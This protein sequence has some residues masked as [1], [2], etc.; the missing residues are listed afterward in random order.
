MTKLFNRHSSAKLT[1]CLS[2]LVVLGAQ[3]TLL[4][5]DTI[6]TDEW[7]IEA[8]KVLRFEDPKSIIAEGN[9]VLTKLR[10]LPPKQ[11]IEEI[12]VSDWADLLEEDSSTVVDK[13]VIT[14]EVVLDET[15]RYITEITI[16]ADWIA[17]DIE[18]NSIKAKGNV[19]INNDTDELL[20]KEGTLNLN[21][22]TGTFKEAMIL[23]ESL[24]LHLE[25]ETITKT[26]TNTYNIKDGWV[27]TCKVAEEKTPPWSFAAKDTDVTQGEYAIM[28]HATFRIKDVPV[29]Y[30]PWLMVP[31]G[32]QRQTGLLF[33]EL[34]NSDRNG[35]GIN[36]PLF[37]NL[38][39]SSDIT[40][41]PEYY[42]NRGF[43]PG[44][45]YRYTLDPQDKGAFMA[46]YLDDDLSDPSETE[47]WQETGYTHTNQER[48]W[49]RGKLDHD[50]ENDIVTRM[51]LDIVSDRDYL[52]EFNS[53]ETGFQD[54]NE[55]FL[56]VFGRG[57]QNKTNDQRE[58]SFKLLKTWDGMALE[59][60]F[61][62]INDVRQDEIIQTQPDL[63]VTDDQITDDQ[64]TD[65]Q[66]TD[67]T[68]PTFETRPTPLWKLPSI[69]FTGSKAIGDTTFTLDWDTDYVYYYR[70]NGIGGHRF[71][72]YPRL[73]VP[74]PLGPYLES[75]AE[76][77]IRDTFYSVQSN[78]DATWDQGDNPNRFLGDFHTE[79]GTT[80]LRDFALDMGD[81]T[82]LTHNFRPY[83]QYDY[84]SDT[85]QDDLPEFDSV[86]R[87][88][89]QNQITY[90]IDNFFDLFGSNSEGD[91]TDR[92]YGFL[93][94]KQ[95]YDLR[96]E[97][98]DNPFSAVKVKLRWDPMDN[99]NLQYKTEIDV[100][101]AG[102]TTHTVEVAYENS[103]GD[104]FNLDYRYDNE[105]DTQQINANARA[106]LFDTI[107]AA[108][109]IEHSISE[110]RVIEQDI[111]LLYKPACW[112][113]ELK[114]RY[115]PG[116]HTISLLFNL[117]NIG[118]PL[119]LTL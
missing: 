58:N 118:N 59:G 82:G 112:S 36:L 85:N 2:S 9:V 105:G 16:K 79:I 96:S 10:V 39:D 55:K 86:D 94:I 32:T 53:G 25:G 7:Q 13:E 46:S 38:S 43:M 97:A 90:G 109:A 24:D 113:V 115:T 88:D 1:L 65:D 80:L 77:G 61:L 5:A 49:V 106:Q 41:Y 17:Y 76:A 35:F 28:K 87:K 45:E 22:E 19:A 111:S 71:D 108:Y 116:D 21:D 11:E 47:Y 119:G 29:L 48:Y 95:S 102:F 23:R 98:S 6:K 70:E 89:H 20:A 27:V 69:D 83:I 64:I 51:D 99:A 74:L 84:L 12:A 107:F 81:T 44:I 30:T 40:L 72:L 68:I 67:A 37:I 34:S 42:A 103:R 66:V 31:V 4:Q 110:S 101:G 78:G 8:D 117:A 92:E 63:E 75:R 93:K 14:Q 54:S 3:P 52:T 100:Y 18:Q 26:G 57:F 114:S 104:Y 50:F 73:S 62:G 91:D 33:P 15:P 56:D 60:V